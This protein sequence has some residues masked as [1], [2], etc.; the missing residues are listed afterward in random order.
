MNPMMAKVPTLQS[1]L[2][3][4]QDGSRRKLIDNQLRLI[5]SAIDCIRIRRRKTYEGDDKSLIVEM[6]DVIA[7][8]FPP[9]NDVPVRKVVVD[10][11]THKW[12][13]TALVSAFEDDSQEK[14]YSLSIPYNFN[15][16]VGDL[17]FRIFLDE[18]INSN[19]VV[20]IEITE[21]L[22]TFGG[23]KMIMMK[24]KGVIPTDTFPEEIVETV[25]EM[26]IRRSKIGY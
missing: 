3:M 22:G 23:Q 1:R 2:A 17:I 19:S 24:C 14:F 13:L 26:S 20:P 5:A 21:L 25:Q 18:D 16:N 9:M 8:V 7:V 6:A 4:I 11:Q 10:P 12:Q 15:I